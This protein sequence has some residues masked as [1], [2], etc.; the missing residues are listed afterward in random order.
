MN[1]DDATVLVVDDLPQNL[2]LMD[3][4]LSPRGFT[5]LTASSGEAALEVLGERLPDVVLLDVDDAGAGRVRDVPPD[6]PGAG[7]VLHP[8]GHGHGERRRR[9]GPRDRGRRGRLH[10]QAPRP[11]RAA[12][13]GPVPREGQALPRHRDGPGRGARGVEREARGQGRGAGVRARAGSAG[14]G[15]SCRPR[16]WGSWWTAGTSRSSRAIA[17]RSRP[18]SPTCGGSRPSPSAPSRRRPWRSWRSTTTRSASSSSQY[19]GTLEH[20]AG[21]GLLVFFNDPVPCPD[22]PDR[23]VRMAV[24]MRARVAELSQL[25]RRRGHD[26]GLRG[27]DRPGVRDARARGVPRS[28]RLRRDRDGHQPRG[29]AVRRGGGRPDPRHPAGAG[30]GP[31]RGRQQGGRPARPQGNQPVGGRARDHRRAGSGGGA[32]ERRDGNRG[33]ALA[34]AG[35]GRPQRDLRRVAGPAAGRVARHPARRP[36]GVGRRR[37]V[38]VGRPRRDRAAA[39]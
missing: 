30:R 7:D 21:D 19:E 2:R 10:H 37:A 22:A 38:H 26:L 3:A 11:G 29:A 39:G 15:A 23:A 6:P 34:G 24:D 25:W 20:F 27:R 18:S 31:G 4:V 5:V 35:R 17:G 36:A 16:S 12:R 9:E 28:I 1:T 14:C 32:H 13:E 33:R 8:R